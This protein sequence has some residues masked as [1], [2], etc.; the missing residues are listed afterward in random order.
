MVR[1]V[2]D[3]TLL[4]MLEGEGSPREREHLWSCATCA[5][6]RARLA[7]DLDVLSGVLG[8]G[9]MPRPVA[10]SAVVRRWVPLA[11]GATVAVAL[12]WSLVGRVPAPVELASV[13]PPSLREVSA[14]VFATDDVEQLAKPVRGP[15]LVAVQAALRGE[16]PCARTDPWLDQDCD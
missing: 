13:E 11:A 7:R 5:G 15:D 16:W 8:D 12:A 3:R 10:R 14:A 9:P 2:S 1:H 6:R 4:G